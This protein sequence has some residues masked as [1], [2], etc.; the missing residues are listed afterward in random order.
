M[1]KLLLILLCFPFLVFSQNEKRLAL[2]IGN[3]DYQYLPMLP[4]PV[5]DALLIAQ[6]LDSL[7]FDVTLDTNISTAR[8]FLD[9]II[10]FGAKR[11]SFEV[12]F[13]FYAGHGMQVNGQN[14]LLPTKEEFNSEIEVERFGVPA[15]TVMRYL[16]AQSDQVNVLILDACRNNPL[17]NYRGGGSGGLAAMQ[18]KGSLIAFSTTAGNVAKDGDGDH[19]V[20]CTSL[21][22]NMLKEGIDLNQVFRNVRKEVMDI[23][24][25][26]TVNYD[27]L[28]GNA[29]YLVRSTYEKQFALIDS[30]VYLGENIHLSEAMGIVSSILKT[31]P[32]NRKALLEKGEIYLGLQD[33]KKALTAYNKAIELFPDDPQCLNYRGR[34]FL[35]ETEEYDKAIADFNKCLKIDSTYLRAYINRANA[36]YYGLEDSDKALADLNKAIELDSENLDYYSYRVELYIGIEDYTNALKDLNTIIELAPTEARSLHYNNR[37]DF[38]KEQ[39]E[40]DLALADYAQAIE[41]NSDDNATSIAINNSANIY[42]EQEKWEL[43]LKEYTKA[44]EIEGQSVYY[45]NRGRIYQK[46]GEYEKAI[47]D[48][49]KAIELDSEDLDYYDYRAECYMEIGE[50]ILALNDYSTAIGLSPLDPERYTERADFY[51]SNHIQEYDLAL[52]DYNTSIELDKERSISYFN[53]GLFY[54]IITQKNIDKGIDDFDQAIKLD[55]LQIDYYTFRAFAYQLIENYDRAISDLD[56]AIELDPTDIGSNV[57]KMNLYARKGEYNKALLLCNELKER[58]NLDGYEWAV[59]MAQINLFFLSG[60]H[61]KALEELTKAIDNTDYNYENEQYYITYLIIQVKMLIFHQQY[62]NAIDECKKI[63][64]LNPVYLDAYFNLGIIFSLQKEYFRSEQYYTTLLSAYAFY[65]DDLPLP[66]RDDYLINGLFFFEENMFCTLGDIYNKRGESYQKLGAHNLMC[67]DYK[68][69]CD[70][71]N[72]EMF[73][74]YCN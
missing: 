64:A 61:E 31:D 5:G 35:Y 57:S 27:Q 60:K 54:S 67:E 68:K 41:I 33:Y 53:R 10:E 30:L 42:W 21:A 2:V 48:I 70:L 63:I 74:K 44:I 25:Q 22:K 52:E 11:D 43:C 47:A 16:T 34:M 1:R 38:Y 32:K 71:G 12:G 59:N 51:A 55:S 56:K 17:E 65:G 18:A 28:T 24:G 69:A 58:K 9:R 37:A 73:E 49:S 50:V 20:Y 62:E 36:Y 45:S 3:S 7:G 19:S 26:A 6:T 39:E 8:N 23:T 46:I 40:Y 13:I 66:I 4:N 14:Y 72:C 15:E 29:F